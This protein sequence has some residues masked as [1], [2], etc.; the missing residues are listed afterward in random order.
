VISSPHPEFLLC[1]EQ[2]KLA[3]KGGMFQVHRARAQQLDIAG[4]LSPSNFLLIHAPI[5]F[6]Q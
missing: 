2:E 4:V 5:F 3:L 1:H 6:Y